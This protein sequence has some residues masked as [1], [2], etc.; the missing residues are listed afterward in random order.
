M[1]VQNE[2]FDLVVTLRNPYVFD[3][4][5]QNVQLRFVFT[6]WPLMQRT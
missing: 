5:L 2:P 6:L 3:L 1:L 4:D